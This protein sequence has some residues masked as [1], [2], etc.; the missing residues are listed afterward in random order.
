MSAWKAS[1]TTSS[2]AETSARPAAGHA[3]SSPA[4]DCDSASDFAFQSAGSPF[5]SAATL[6]AA[7]F[8]AATEPQVFSSRGAPLSMW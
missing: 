4:I 5:G 2:F 8:I 7:S 3:G 6:P 1:C